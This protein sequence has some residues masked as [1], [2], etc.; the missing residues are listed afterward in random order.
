MS[1]V[2]VYDA[3]REY[4]DWKVWEVIQECQAE[5]DELCA[6]LRAY[7]E[8]MHSSRTQSEEPEI[9]SLPDDVSVSARATAAYFAPFGEVL[10]ML[11]AKEQRSVLQQVTSAQRRVLES[12][13][14]EVETF[15][16]AEHVALVEA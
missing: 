2:H 12:A 16:A 5:L 11:P 10:A 15:R 3:T 6:S 14:V 8:L 13:R 4:R 1:S 9:P 7:Y